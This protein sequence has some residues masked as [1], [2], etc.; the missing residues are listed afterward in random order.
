MKFKFTKIIGAAVVLLSPLAATGTVLADT[1]SATTYEGEAMTPLSGNL[2]VNY[3]KGYGIRVYSKPG[4]D[5]S[6]DRFL[7]SGSTWKV[8]GS[9]NGYYNVGKDQWVEQSYSVFPV[10]NLDT[11]GY[12][13]YGPYYTV[14][15][16]NAPGIED[17]HFESHGTAIHITHKAVVGGETWYKFNKVKNLDYWWNDVSSYH[18]NDGVWIKSEYVSF[19]PVYTPVGG[20]YLQIQYIKGYGVRVFQTPD[21][22]K[23]T[24]QYLK[25]GTYWKVFGYQNGY[26]HVGNNQWVQTPYAALYDYNHN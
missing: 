13:N 2:L 8:F 25:D 12:I 1:N 18:G 6:T 7:P 16:Y 20:S 14:K 24:N 17:D 21:G 5:F 9:Q 4:I 23:P 19:N 22:S 10:E 26:Y 3:K 11:I 15:T